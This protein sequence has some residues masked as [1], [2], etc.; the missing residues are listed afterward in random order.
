MDNIKHVRP[1]EMRVSHRISRIH[2]RINAQAARIL[3][4]SADIS[5]SQWRILVMV[6][7]DGEVSASEIVRRTKIDKAMVSRAI[8]SL[9]QAGLVQVIVSK[10]D[11]RLHKVKMTDAG[12]ARFEKALPH[13]LARQ[14]GLMAPFDEEEEQQLFHLLAKLEDAIAAMEEDETAHKTAAE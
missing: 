13:M 9:S 2:G 1:L 12:R 11:Q 14:D 4:E 10:T 5:L 6:D 7:A 3:S 8:K